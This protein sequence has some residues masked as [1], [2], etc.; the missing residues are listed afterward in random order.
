M[1]RDKNTS[2]PY[3]AK[4]A[5]DFRRNRDF[6]KIPGIGGDGRIQKS[7]ASAA[8]HKIKNGGQLVREAAKLIQGGGG[9]QPHFATAGGKNPDGLNAAVDKVVELAGF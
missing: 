3:N 4:F 6:N 2:F 7:A 1:I 8:T 9:G 5:G